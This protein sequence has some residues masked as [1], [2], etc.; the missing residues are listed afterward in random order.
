MWAPAAR[1]RL[2]ALL[3]HLGDVAMQLPHQFARQRCS[4]RLLLRHG[5][6]VCSIGAI[7]HDKSGLALQNWCGRQCHLFSLLEKAK[8]H[9]KTTLDAK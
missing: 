4:M 6:Q 8:W 1:H 7:T 9:A 3:T 5:G 2:H